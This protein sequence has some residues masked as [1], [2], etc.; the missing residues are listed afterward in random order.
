MDS[1]AEAGRQGVQLLVFPETFIPNYPYF[2]SWQAPATITEQHLRLFEQSVEIPGPVTRAVGVATA[3]AGIVVVGVNE[4][5]GGS[6]YNTQV[7]F[8]ADGTLLAKRR[9]LMPTYQERII[10]G[11]GDGS[12]LKVLDTAVGRVGPLICWEHYM[13]LCRYALMLQ[14]EEIHCSHFP[15]YIG[16]SGFAVEVE[17]TI[18]HHA[19]E[20]GCF[21]VNAT[22][23]LNPDQLVELCPNPDL[24]ERLA[25]D[26]SY[27]AIVGP[28][29]RHLAEPVIEGEGMVIADLDLQAINR[30]K[31]RMDSVGHYARPDVVR[32]LLDPRPQHT[33][34]EAAFGPNLN[35]GQPGPQPVESPDLAAR[36]A[37]LEEELRRLKGE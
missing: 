8:D 22:G 7:V 1:I 9:K 31:L 28:D 27:T 5:D 20:S 15:G 34:E 26:S 4:R 18:R 29:G 14:Q 37:E 30:R 13:P 2:A 11:W 10:W 17:V 32:L 6:L 12:D 3:A 36:V 24:R 19:M 33:L 35:T 23:W 25:P 21:V 16:R